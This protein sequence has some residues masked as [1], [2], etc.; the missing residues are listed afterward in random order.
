M[1]LIGILVALAVLAAATAA[2]AKE[3]TKVTACGADGCVTTRD[4]AVLQGMTNG[5]PPTVP[6]NASSPVVR[7]RAAVAE[8]PG[9]RAVAHFTSFWVPEPRLLVTE[10]GSWMRLPGA[11]ARALTKLTAGLA[12]L[13][14]STIAAA[15]TSPEPPPP[16]LKPAAP[17]AGGGIDW[18][19]VA[20]IAAFAVAGALLLVVLLRRRPR[21]GGAPHPAAP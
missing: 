12:P 16:P 2:S 10:D 9:G 17:D 8:R 21:E 20:P 5:G 19:L 7:L 4:P 3:I 11:A 6:P 14:A 15:D 18:L 1:R 13:P